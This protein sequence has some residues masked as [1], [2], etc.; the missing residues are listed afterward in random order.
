MLL[1]VW[2]LMAGIPLVQGQEE[3]A[4]A[5]N[6]DQVEEEAA[7]VEAEPAREEAVEEPI[8]PDEEEEEVEEVPVPVKNEKPVPAKRDSPG[9]VEKVVTKGKKLFDKIKTL[10][11]T[12]S[13]K[14]AAALLGICGISA[15]VGWMTQAK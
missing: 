11:Q 9:M 10:V 6:V 7:P 15:A 2:V 12:K 4:P 5:V 1:T 14:I 8:E 13:K 3:A